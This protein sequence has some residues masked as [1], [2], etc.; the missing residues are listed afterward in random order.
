MAE[1]SRILHDHLIGRVHPD[2]GPLSTYLDAIRF[3]SGAPLRSL[4]EGPSQAPPK[5]ADVVVSGMEKWEG[6]V[7]EV[8]DDYFTAEITPLS[9]EGSAV[10]ADFSTELLY[11]EVVVPGDVVYVTVRT[12]NHGRGYGVSRTSSVRLRRLGV[13]TTEEVEQI[14]ARGRQRFEDVADYIE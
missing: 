4:S 10:Y 8:E 9:S 7:V 12:V 1:S 2:V 3:A 11:P 5:P 6:R 14:K 13:W